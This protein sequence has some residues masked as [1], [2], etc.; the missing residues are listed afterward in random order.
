MQRRTCHSPLG[1]DEGVCGHVGWLV[2]LPTPDHDSRA[3]LPMISPGWDRV[4][5]R[6]C[7]LPKHRRCR[8]LSDCSAFGEAW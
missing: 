1:P 8:L 6:P 2:A 5:D 3:N 7:L 4:L